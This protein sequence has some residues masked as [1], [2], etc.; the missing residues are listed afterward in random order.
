MVILLKQNVRDYDSI[1]V[2]SLNKGTGFQI[3][4]QQA[5]LSSE[6]S[7]VNI[8]FKEDSKVRITFV[9]EQQ[10]LNRFIY[11]YI[12]G[13]MCGVTQYPESDNFKQVEPVG[14][15][16][17]AESCGLDLYVLRFYSKGL[18]R[19]EQLNNFICDRPTLAARKE[20]YERNNV[21]DSN[22]QVALASLPLSIPYMILECEEL[23]QYKGDK[24]KE[25]S[26][27]YV[28]PL[29][30]ERSFTAAGV[31]FNVQGTS[32]QGYPVKNYKAD[33][34]KGIDY[35]LSGEHA[36]GWPINVGDLETT[37][38]CL[39]AD[40]AS[41]ENAN[42]TCLASYYDELVPYKTPAQ[43]ADDRIQ[44]TVRGNPI[45][46]FWRNTETNDIKF[47]GK[48]NINVDK[49]NENIF[50]FNREI[51]PALE[52]WE[53][54]NNTSNRTLFKSA[55]FTSTNADGEPAWLDDFEARFPDLDEPYQDCTALKRFAEW[56]VST[57]RDAEGLTEEEK[58]ARLQKFKDEYSQYMTLTPYI[59]Y[60]LFTEV[61]LMVDSR[62]KN[63]FLTTWDGVHWEPFCYDLDTANGIV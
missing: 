53:F 38:F 14:I 32:S 50:G 7:K 20:A 22:D 52:C 30:P 56:L 63:L 27:T 59:Y 29:H 21:L 40:F 43:E 49:S 4:S 44:T 39:K 9:V 54:L 48:Y 34:K 17:G 2:E 45:V 60:Y 25:K 41:S 13:V 12:N 8:Q 15:T 42:N 33:C 23:P 11:V 3:K 36:K 35:T 61:F 10:N 37:C 57:D 26:L 46:V 24:K 18:T 58:T 1:V 5:S 51:Y 19:H 47:L 55:D 28:E 6:Q 16:I 31:Q 62:A